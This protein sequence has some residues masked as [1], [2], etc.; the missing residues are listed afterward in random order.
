MYLAASA[1]KLG[2]D[3]KLVV[4]ILKC[5]GCILECIERIVEYINV[6]AFCYVAVSGDSFCASGL[7]ALMLNLKHCAKFSFANFLAKIFIYL[8]KIGLC[9]GNVFS[10][11]FI[12]KLRGD[13]EEVSSNFGPIVVIAVASYLTASIFLGMF[14]TSVMAILT[15]LAVDMDLHDGDPM[16]GPPTFH[17]EEGAWNK[18]NQAANKREEARK[19]GTEMV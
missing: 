13:N 19:V 2:G 12:M 11:L 8:G 15:C 18:L 6:A 7:Q 4:C 5:A 10:L 1:E 17:G 16:Y 3:N 14:D 9:V